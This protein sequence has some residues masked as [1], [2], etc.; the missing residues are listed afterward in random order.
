MVDETKIDGIAV[1]EIY[2]NL[3]L[4]DMSGEEWKDVEGYEGLYMISSYGRVKSLG[5]CNSNNSKERILK[6][7]EISN[8]YLHVNLYKDGKMKIY[9]VHRLVSHEFIPNPLNLPEVNHISEP[10]YDESNKDF[11]KKDNRVANLEYCDHKY[12]INYGTHNERQSKGRINHKGISKK[13]TCIEN[14]I[15]YPSLSE[16]ERQTGI[17]KSNI[18][19]CCKGKLKSAGKLH[20]KYY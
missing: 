14:G 13:I 19:K 1:Y 15:V 20:W 9:T 11:A 18:S 17:F 8:G 4:K 7:I 6:L 10:L 5:N 12:N 2:K 16:A 3:S